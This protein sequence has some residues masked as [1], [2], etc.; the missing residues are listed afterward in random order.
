MKYCWHIRSVI[1]MMHKAVQINIFL[2]VIKYY[3]ENWL[4]VTLSND[5]SVIANT[6][7]TTLEPYDFDDFT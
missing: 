6:Q 4:V 7:M 1:M 5:L 3:G 2:L